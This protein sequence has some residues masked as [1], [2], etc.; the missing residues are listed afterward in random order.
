MER[1]EGDIADIDTAAAFHLESHGTHD[2]V[3]VLLHNSW[4]ETVWRQVSVPS[5]LPFLPPLVR[6]PARLVWPAAL[7]TVH[8]PLWSVRPST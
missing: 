2:C 1:N 7:L 3:P 6:P 8:S 4:Y 5:P